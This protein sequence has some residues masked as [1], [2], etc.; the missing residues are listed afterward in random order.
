MVKTS[1]EY[2]TVVLTFERNTQKL[3]YDQL[4]SLKFSFLMGGLYGR[5][6]FYMSW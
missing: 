4:L 6:A 1:W 3:N 2:N 5:R